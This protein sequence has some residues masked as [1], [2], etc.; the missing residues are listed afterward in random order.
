METEANFFIEFHEVICLT[1]NAVFGRSTVSAVIDQR[2][3]R[4]A[5][6]MLIFRDENRDG[7]LK[8]QRPDLPF[9]DPVQMGVA[10]KQN[11][12]THNRRRGQLAAVDLAFG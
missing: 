8:A 10:A 6:L 2:P 9:L 3:P 4:A 1:P 5:S 11:R 7:K 12:I